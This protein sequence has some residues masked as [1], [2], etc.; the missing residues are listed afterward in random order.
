MSTGR[1]LYGW[2]TRTH[3]GTWSLVGMYTAQAGHIA[4]VSH[5]RAMIE[6]ARLIAQR[7]AKSSGQRVELV[8][9][10]E[11]EVLDVITP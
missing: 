4:M 7:H 11:C 5:D 1:E 8:C 6:G 3:E 2:A 10:R 9:W